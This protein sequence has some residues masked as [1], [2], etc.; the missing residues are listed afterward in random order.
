MSGPSA[1]LAVVLQN[2]LHEVPWSKLY[3]VITVSTSHLKS[4]ETNINSTT[5]IS[6]FTEVY[7]TILLNY[8][9]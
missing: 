1:G 4:N 2:S 8:A 3:K 5:Y 9:T 7:F 6:A